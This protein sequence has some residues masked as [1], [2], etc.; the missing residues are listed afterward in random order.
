MVHHHAQYHKNLGINFIVYSLMK[1][2]KQMGN[3][4]QM[5]NQIMYQQLLLEPYYFITLNSH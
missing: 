3:L 2:R 4:L 5:G 1:S